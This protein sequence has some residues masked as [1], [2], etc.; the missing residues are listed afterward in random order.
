[1]GRLPPGMR[2]VVRRRR[3]RADEAGEA[4]AAG[5]EGCWAGRGDG[6][7]VAGVARRGGGAAGM[8]VVALQG[9]ARLGVPRVGLQH[10]SA[11]FVLAVS[12]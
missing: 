11:P 2:R 9:L 10:E 7:R 6:R 3:H 8:G 5:G 1:M 12:R 4:V